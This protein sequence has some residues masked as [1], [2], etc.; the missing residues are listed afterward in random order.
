MQ[1]GI[2]LEWP[3]ICISISF[4]VM[5]ILL[6][7]NYILSNII[8]DKCFRLLLCNWNGHLYC[9]FGFKWCIWYLCTSIILSIKEKLFE[10]WHLGWDVRSPYNFPIYLDDFLL[11]LDRLMDEEAFVW[12]VILWHFLW[13]HGL[14]R[15]GTP[16]SVLS[17]LVLYHITLWSLHLLSPLKPCA[18]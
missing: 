11:Y 9:L 10:R 12:M 4:R 7:E 17:Q 15:H 18:L 14:G 3:V 1:N 2:G 16:I 6:S 13:L 5:P 8:N